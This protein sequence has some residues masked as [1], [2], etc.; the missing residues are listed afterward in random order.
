M[1]GSFLFIRENT[2][3][4][5]DFEALLMHYRDAKNPEN[6]Y[7]VIIINIMNKSNSMESSYHLEF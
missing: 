1:I 2:Q 5:L 6:K 4:S 3:I 7:K